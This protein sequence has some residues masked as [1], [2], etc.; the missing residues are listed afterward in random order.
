MHITS[1]VIQGPQRQKVREAEPGVEE[2]QRRRQE[3]RRQAQPSYQVRRL[4][5]APQA[6]LEE[7]TNT[8]SH[9]ECT[10]QL[11]LAHGSSSD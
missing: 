6:V 3:G 11:G 9:C 7:R 4:Q 8:Y 2:R 10:V 1:Q 5:Q